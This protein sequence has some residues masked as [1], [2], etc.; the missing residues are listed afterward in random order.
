MTLCIQITEEF[1]VTVGGNLLTLQILE[2]AI[3]EEP[4]V[5]PLSAGMTSKIADIG[6]P[7]AALPDP[8]GLAFSGTTGEVP[9]ELVHLN[10]C[11]VLG[12]RGLCKQLRSGLQY[13]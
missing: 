2:G 13:G 5:S 1:D 7:Y 6:D 11:H 4:P 8:S 3:L 10:H 12:V 9:Q